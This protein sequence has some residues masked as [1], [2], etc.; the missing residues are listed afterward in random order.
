M[1]KA[2][3]VR[4][5]RVP[6]VPELKPETKNG[7]APNRKTRRTTPSPLEQTIT[8]IKQGMPCIVVEIAPGKPLNVSWLNGTDPAAAPF[9]LREAAQVVERHF[10]IRE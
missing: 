10:G 6:S 9:R 3:R 2:T 1:S 8:R 5:A 4:Q 7:D